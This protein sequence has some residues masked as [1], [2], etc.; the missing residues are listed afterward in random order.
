MSQDAHSHEHSSPIKTPAQLI[1]VVVLSFIIP[2]ALIAMLAHLVTGGSHS[3]KGNPAM[4]EEA[5]A[6]RLKPVGE[7]A[8][9]PNGN[10][11]VAGYSNSNTFPTNAAIQPSVQ[12]NSTSLFRTSNTGANWTPLD[13][14]LPGGGA[15]GFSPDPVNA[16]TFVASTNS[17]TYRT[18]NNG[19][20]WT[21][22]SPV[23]FI[24]HTRSRANPVIIYGLT[25]GQVYQSIDNGVTWNFKGTLPKCCLEG[26]IA[27]PLNAAAAYVKDAAQRR[28]G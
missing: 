28:Y 7:V 23:R 24:T 15:L 21:Q 22:Q 12:G 16:G 2:I 19:S 10:A 27:D 4:S 3:E 13:T 5:I 8:I 18:T 14:N 26:F 17:G 11:Y 1:T 9:D 20:T 6:K 25:G